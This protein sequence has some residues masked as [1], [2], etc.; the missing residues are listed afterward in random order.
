MFILF[1]LFDHPV[2]SGT[3]D[4]LTIYETQGETA[5][6]EYLETKEWGVIKS[7]YSFSQ[8]MLF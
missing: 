8:S 5:L 6:N 2:L 3:D 4:F 1:D 7:G